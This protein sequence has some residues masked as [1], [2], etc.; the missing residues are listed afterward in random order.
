MREATIE[1]TRSNHRWPTRAVALL[2][3]WVFSATTVWSAA[4]PVP[5]A[6]AAADIPM[7]AGLP[8]LPPAEAAPPGALPETA[9]WKALGEALQAEDAPIAP[10]V[11]VAASSFDPSLPAWMLTSP[12]PQTSPSP[13]PSATPTP[14]ATACERVF[15][16]PERFVRT[17]GPKNEYLRTISVPSWV[18][19]PYTLRVQNGEPD[20]RNRVSSAWIYVNGAEVAVP[21]DF[22]QNVPG[23]ERPVTLTPTTQLRVVL[24][25]KPS[26]YLTI[27]LCGASGDRTPPRVRWTA[28]PDGATIPDATPALALAYQDAVGTGEP[29]ASG[30]DVPTLA[31]SLDDVNRTN[32]FAT[33]PDGASAEV[34]PSLALAEG[35]HRL[36]AAIADVAGNP[37]EA[38]STFVVDVTPPSIQAPEPAR[39]AYLRTLSPA[40]R[41]T[42]AD[43]LGLDLQTLEILV[44]GANRTAELAAGATEA[45]ATLTLSS[46]PHE[47]VAHVRD[48]AGNPSLPGSTSFNLDVTPPVVTISHPLPDTRHGTSTVEAIV[49]YHDDQALDLPT[50]R[51]EVDGVPVSLGQ[52][53]DGAMGTLP[54]LPDGE[55]RLLVRIK[56]RAGNDQSAQVRFWVDTAVPDITV[57]QPPP[58]F[59][60][61]TA[62]P[63]VLVGYGDAQGVDL[64]T[65]KLSIGAEDRTA[66]CQVGPDSAT[67]AIPASSRLPEGANVAAAEIKDLTGNRATAASEFTIDTIAPTGGME[68]PEAITNT[69]HPAIKLS[70]AD[71]GTGIDVA[72][73]R[74]ALDGQDRTS[75]FAR[76]EASALGTPPEPLGEGPHQAVLTVSDRAGNAA[77]IEGAFTVD[78]VGPT[79]SVDVPAGGSFINDSTPQIRVTYGDANGSG[80]APSSLKVFLRADEGPETEIT[81]LFTVGE[82]EAVA[83][84]PDGSALTDGTHSLRVEIRDRATN[85]GGAQAQFVLDTVAPTYTV[86]DPPAGEFLSTKTPAFAIRYGD[87]RSGVDPTTL[88]LKVDAVDLTARLVRGPAEATGSLLAGDALAEGRHP[89]FVTVSDRAGNPALPVPHDFVVDT[90]APVAAVVEPPASAYLG[91]VQTLVRVSY[92]DTDAG[93]G[94][95]VG[96]VQVLVDGVDRTLEF[97]VGAT[98]A[99]AHVDPPLGDGP[100]VVTV[101]VRDWADNPATASSTFVIDTQAPVVSLTSPAEGS[102]HKATPIS[103]EGT[104]ADA[105]PQVVVECRRGDV[106]VPA[107]VE[108]APP[109]AFV[110]VPRGF[111]CSVPLAEGESSILAAA[112]DRFEREGTATRVV[113]LDTVAPQVLIETPLAGVCTSLDSLTVGG[114]VIDASPVTVTV[115]GMT[116][117]CTPTGGGACTFN[118]PGVPLG[119]G[120]VATLNVAAEDA[121]GNPSPPASVAVCVDRGAPSVKVRQPA[122]GAYVRGPV[123]TV[124]GDV[125]DELT[126]TTVEVNGQAESGGSTALSRSFTAQVPVADGDAVGL[127]A[128]A[129]DAAGNRGT[130]SLTVHVDSAPPSIAFTSPAPN[131]VTRATAITVTG[132]VDDASPVMLT[133]GGRSVPVEPGGTFSVDVALPAEG[134]VAIPFAATDAAGNASPPAELHVVVDRT[135]PTL[136]IV[137]PSP[138]VVLGALPII[139]QGTVV[140]ATS[141]TVTV[142]GQAAT[143]TGQAW[144]ASFASLPEGNHRFTVVATD[145]AGNDTTKT[146]DVFV[147]LSPPEVAITQPPTGTLTREGGIPVSGTVQ[148][149]STVTVAVNGVP[150]AAARTSPSTW[151]FTATVPLQEGTQALVALATDAAG[152]TDDDQVSVTRDSTPPVVVLTAPPQVSRG[153]PGQA[154]AVVTDP[155]L[156]RIVVKWGSLE[157]SCTSSPCTLD[158]IVPGGVTSGT[159]IAVTAAATD[160]AGNEGAAVPVGVKVVADGVLTGQ[161]LSD[162]TSLV[163]PGATVV[164]TAGTNQAT[165]TADEDGRFSL[166]TGESFATLTVS[167]PGH[168]TVHRD[169]TVSS[170]VGTVPVDARLTPLAPPITIGLGGGNLA[171]NVP[172]AGEALTPRSP[173]VMIAVPENAVGPDTTFRLTWLSPQGLPALLPLG[174][175]SVAAFDLDAS[176]APS[177]LLPAQ[178]T[179]A[180][181]TAPSDPVHLVRYDSVRRG[182]VVRAR[183]LTADGSHLA[184]SLPQTGAY[185]FVLGDEPDIV[186]PPVDETLA[187]VPMVPL[188]VTATSTGRVDPAVVAPTGGTAKGSI[189]VASS[190]PLPSGTVVQAE[191]TETYTLRETDD[192]GANKTASAEKRTVDIVLFRPRGGAAGSVPPLAADTMLGAEVP[193]TPSRVYGRAEIVKGEVVLDILAGREGV[194]GL[195]GGSESVDLE[196]GDA[197]L[198]V[199]ANALGEDTAFSLEV[200]PS[201]SSFLPSAAGLTPLAEVAVDFSG[202]TLSIP[203]ALSV[204][205]AGETPDATFLVAQVERE[206]TDGLPRLFVVAVAQL[207][208]ERLST[209]PRPGLPGIVEGGRYVFFRSAPVGFVAGTVVAGGSPV[210]ALVE[211]VL[212]PP[213]PFIGLSRPDGS[214]VLA[215]PPGTFPV[216]ATV[217]KSP[218]VGQASVTVSADETTALTL[219]LTGTATTLTPTPLDGSVG[220]AVNA[221]LEIRSSVPLKAS[222]VVPA[223]FRLFKGAVELNQTV[224]LRVVLAQGGR[225]VSL[226]PVPTPLPPDAPPDAVPPPA[227]AFATAYHLQVSGLRDAFDN[228]IAPL[229]VSF[230]TKDDTPEPRDLRKLVISTPGADGLVTITAPEGTFLPGTT[231]LIINSGNGYV[232]T[233]DAG[234]A[235][236]VNGELEAG[237]ADQLLIT[238][239][240][241]DGHVTSLERSQYFDAA[242]GTT[243]VGAGGGV[244]EGPN[245]E[246]LRI[247]EGALDKPIK[248]KVTAL[249]QEEYEQAFPDKRLPDDPDAHF[250]SVLKIEASQGA[251]FKKELD[252]AFPMP[253]GLD[254]SPACETGGA[255]PC[256]KDANFH[257][258]R[259]LEGPCRDGAETCPAADHI[260]YFE[261][262]DDAFMEGEGANRKVVTASYPFSGYR[263][264][265]TQYIPGFGAGFADLG[266]AGGLLASWAFVVWAVNGLLP[267]QPTGGVVTGR[268]LEPVWEPGKSEPVYKGVAGALVKRVDAGADPDVALS[269]D[270]TGEAGRFTLKD[271][272]FAGGIVEVEANHG[273]QTYKATAFAIERNDT[274]ADA[275]PALKALIEKGYWKNIANVNITLPVQPAPPPP[276]QFG[277]HVMKEVN[278]RREEVSTVIAGTPLVIGFTTAAEDGSLSVV[279]SATINGQG[280]NVAREAAPPAVLPMTYV[281]QD[282]DGPG[283]KVVLTQAGSYTITATAIPPIGPTMTEQKVFR[284]LAA[285]GGTTEAL[286]GAPGVIAVEPGR[287]ATDVPVSIFPVLTF[288]EPVTNVP[289]NV[290][291]TDS[292]GGVV[293]LNL[294]GVGVDAGGQPIAFETITPT[295]RV[296]SLTMEPVG[297]LKFGETY[298]LSALAGIKDLDRNGEGQPAPNALTPFQSTFKTFAPAALPVPPDQTQMVG[299]AVMDDRAYA[300]AT[301]YTGGSGGALQNSQLHVYNI[302]DPANPEDIPPGAAIVYPGRDVAVIKRTIQDA[303]QNQVEEKLAAVAAG[304]RTYWYITAEG[305]Y[306]REL[307]STPGNVFIYNVDQDTPRWVGA[308]SLTGNIID[309][310]S[311]RIAMDGNTLFSATSR[312]GIQ[313]VDLAAAMSGFEDEIAAPGG[314][315]EVRKRLYNE[316]YRAYAVVQTF[317]IA[318]PTNPQE[319]YN[320]SDLKVGRFNLDGAP[321]RLVLATIMSP[322]AA[323]AIVNPDTGEKIYQGKVEGA[324]GSLYWAQVVALA[325]VGGRDLALVGGIT[326]ASTQAVA[327]LDMTDPRAFQIL[328]WVT[329]PHSIGDILVRDATAIV[330]GDRG[331]RAPDGTLGVATLIDLTNPSQP[332]LAGTISGVGGRIALAG[333]SLLLSTQRDII[334][335]NPTELSG[336]R[337]ATFDV[338]PIIPRPSVFPVDRKSKSLEATELKLAVVPAST[339]VETAELEIYRDGALQPGTIQLPAFTGGSYTHTFPAGSSFS[340]DSRYQARLVINRGLGNRE[341]ASGRQNLR[342]ARM[343]LLDTAEV[344]LDP[345]KD[346]SDVVRMFQSAPQIT[347]AF[348]SFTGLAGLTLGAGDNVTV[349]IEGTVSSAVAPIE[350][351]VV[352]EQIVPVTPTGKGPQNLGPFTGRYQAGVQVGPQDELVT[353]YAVD[354]LDHVST[355]SITVTP[356]ERLLGVIPG[357]DVVTL[358]PLVPGP[359]DAVPFRFRV[360]LRDKGSSVS[361]TQVQIVSGGETRALTLKKE[362]EVFRSDP[363]LALPENL[364]LPAS[365]DQVVKDTRIKARPGV[366]TQI[367]YGTVEARNLVAGVNVLAPTAPVEAVDPAAAQAHVVEVGQAGLAG[368]TMTVTVTSLDARM[369]AL[370]PGAFPVTQTLTLTRGSDDVTSP[371]FNVYAARGSDSLLPLMDG[372]QTDAAG[373][374]QRVVPFGRL[375][376][377]TASDSLTLP[378]GAG[379]DRVVWETVEVTPKYLQGI[380]ELLFGFTTGP[381]LPRWWQVTQSA[382]FLRGTTPIPGLTVSGFLDRRT[383]EVDDDTGITALRP[384]GADWVA[385]T[386]PRVTDEQGKIRFRVK[387]MAVDT[388][389]TQPLAGVVLALTDE[390]GIRAMSLLS[391]GGA[392]PQ[393]P[394]VTDITSEHEKEFKA[395]PIVGGYASA[396][397][398]PRRQS[399]WYKRLAKLIVDQVVGQDPDLLAIKSAL[400]NGLSDKNIFVTEEQLQEYFTYFM[401]GAI[402]GIP[403]GAVG[404]FVDSL[405]G[406]W[407]LKGTIGPLLKFFSPHSGAEALLALTFVPFAGPNAVLLARAILNLQYITEQRQKLHDLAV[408]LATAA[409][410]LAREEIQAQLTVSL[411]STV[412]NN[413]QQELGK[414]V[415]YLGFTEGD[416]GFRPLVLGYS[417]GSVGGYLAEFGFELV[418]A[419]VVGEGVGAMLPMVLKSARIPAVGAR[420]VAALQ[421][422]TRLA[423]A[424]NEGPKFVRAV[425]YL[426]KFLDAL[427]PNVLEKWMLRIA[428]VPEGPERMFTLLLR[429]GEEADA[430]ARLMAMAKGLTG[431]VA[432]GVRNV[433]HVVETLIMMQRMAVD[434]EFRGTSRLVIVGAGNAEA[435]SRAVGR[436]VDIGADTPELAGRVQLLLAN[437]DDAEKFF[438]TFGKL[439]DVTLEKALKGALEYVPCQ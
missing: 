11:S 398:I 400:R 289:G 429:Y 139:V 280:K 184:A 96:E 308:V 31:V 137:S 410:F 87:D 15:F 45:T 240:D 340:A 68:L 391:T 99:E 349:N 378:V 360:E 306:V 281:V 208:G 284:V 204:R 329:L 29:G 310:Y 185:A 201:L 346:P 221:P 266:L 269:Q 17:N 403:R 434:T 51:A 211:G 1:R 288:S 3:S 374:R 49:Q 425:T 313:V 232:L 388:G 56:D 92:G 234:N 263:N 320:L 80:V 423:L 89:V 356:R 132:R 394:K 372:I 194:R 108:A 353:A 330:S 299:M 435:F 253:S 151:S 326:A 186:A 225:A 117:P 365:A 406:V 57:I 58:G 362:G 408:V 364:K 172:A 270:T 231:I 65:F 174:W 119:A 342:P 357:R 53:P 319:K 154:M 55:H 381:S 148:E 109:G 274:S 369:G 171:L 229:E 292:K 192:S 370:A 38:L 246:E 343:D 405:V 411:A 238:I 128:V 74:V 404:G 257:V 168:T 283:G 182:W 113:V 40:I 82:T 207:D 300:L 91:A 195:V 8:P 142:D 122:A 424:N 373:R 179:F 153:R 304:S 181:G 302:S 407:E 255:T 389:S 127:V 279:N 323:L 402:V 107:A 78:T 309:G 160:V 6:A 18:V 114:S 161:V 251:V 245:G 290:T 93:A 187:G 152:R 44:D 104:V 118:A 315:F 409:R 328:A 206:L 233:L 112:H 178:V 307:R 219:A 332:V 335:G 133:Q 90:V 294:A 136:T 242:T 155:D 395:T 203:A 264:G 422:V 421:K 384:E 123:L 30:V 223:S 438:A 150:A 239:T 324:G 173:S 282:P 322:N 352:N 420:V 167:K 48:R 129:R 377:E 401:L 418:G 135:A 359:T 226:I 243:F 202:R 193:I 39:G 354:S 21:S 379:A 158:L 103:V 25:S 287:G 126:P 95:G 77:T 190:V 382:T 101:N 385:T 175:A 131:T 325:K 228:E 191:V 12:E 277:I 291:L 217:P 197:R 237:V 392:L 79:A 285:G 220:V 180:E 162:V 9:L 33:R 177:V 367:K 415:G 371:A 115:Q 24:A 428:E 210:R 209:V 427:G 348:K 417:I 258:Y 102:A 327:I 439:D 316:G 60:L 37:G 366:A 272:R 84:I 110:G 430:P 159:T 36:R 35:T 412:L 170:G 254:L 305:A 244:V 303:Q 86:L 52:G 399:E 116:T 2:L 278:G 273:G 54:P 296:T 88:N 100:H 111:A 163:L 63:L 416:P 140:D 334:K 85:P 235:G 141:T 390:V 64:A 215:V 333:S 200:P 59:L 212:T 337:A 134:D 13:T 183:E 189:E 397:G 147:D 368:N 98:Q 75:W 83:T 67:C 106:T 224:E 216:K 124:A 286:P 16:G 314:I 7:P 436:L 355:Q 4:P 169:V 5:P 149:T 43:N 62:T 143:R 301:E 120:P 419:S 248:F 262:L 47:V 218:Y 247:P 196:A 432:G 94:N 260:A 213:W 293:T 198:S 271:R 41:V 336:I 433:D 376:V 236:E 414:L 23:L 61:N 386:F 393:L 176:A 426:I 42:Y 227:L 22:N 413:Y 28:P 145:E 344:T 46:G 250:G 252:L 361:S 66:W 311:N 317:P 214:F 345:E 205:A 81:S 10:A 338:L 375:R 396:G 32:L 166:P 351:V 256:A 130:D 157:A 72:T 199:P 383:F 156:S 380:L 350:R 241:P 230:T 121:A 267:G 341:K 249:T 19:N 165:T 261:T 125:S 222:T 144:Q 70:Y 265:Y 71:S 295:S 76:G 27:N 318:N 431:D 312:K 164:M 437:V 26:S 50:F 34:P 20:G 105:D 387:A 259:R 363:L 297:A 69:A 73:V 276:A 97:T 339:K 358:D 14:P 146:V 188:P 331:S 321:A 298:T 268:V 138:D 347:L 275:D